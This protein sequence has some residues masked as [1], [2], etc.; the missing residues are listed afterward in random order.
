VTRFKLDGTPDL[1]FKGNRDLFLEK[2]RNK[3]GTLDMRF[4]ENKDKLHAKIESEIA[5][6][7]SREY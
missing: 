6:R 4:K 3:D 7:W 2:G 5:E 1:R